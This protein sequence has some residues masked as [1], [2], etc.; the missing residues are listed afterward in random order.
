MVILTETEMPEEAHTQ[1][2]ADWEESVF[3]GRLTPRPDALDNAR[4]LTGYLSRVAHG[5]RLHPT[6]GQT[7]Y[8]ELADEDILGTEK[9]TA[10]AYSPARTAVWVRPEADLTRIKTKPTRAPDDFL[11]GA[12]ISRFMGDATAD[13]PEAANAPLS[14]LRCFTNQFTTTFSQKCHTITLTRGNG[15]GW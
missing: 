2:D 7:T 13:V 14:T 6:P 9:L 3:M 8:V 5:W 12:L 15:C 11:R 4:L 1:R 10:T